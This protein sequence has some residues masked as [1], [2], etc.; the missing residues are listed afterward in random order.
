M[1]AQ[2]CSLSELAE[3][4][5]VDTIPEAS[6]GR[7]QHVIGQASALVRA[8]LG[9][10]LTQ[11]WVNP[12]DAPDDVRATVADVAS[13]AFVTPVNVTQETEAGVYGTTFETA[14]VYLTAANRAVL[15]AVRRGLSGGAPGRPLWTLPT[16]GDSDLVG[17]GLVPVAG[18]E[19]FLALGDDVP[20]DERTLQLRRA[21]GR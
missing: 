12:E 17:L 1:A 7:A 10:E 3:A 18:G 16:A 15:A 4:S 13:R 11:A 2:L 8:E 14:A 5:G 20:L 9:Y 21:L 6:Q 19:P